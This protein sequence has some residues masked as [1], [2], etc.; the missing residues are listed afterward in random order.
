MKWDSIAD[1]AEMSEW[2]SFLVDIRLLEQVKIP[3]PFIPMTFTVVDLRMYRLS[4]ASELG[5]GAAVYVWVGGDDER[6]M[7]SILMGKSCV[8]PIKSVTL[9]IW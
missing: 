8:S 2:H 6:V 4:D 1:E 9:V 7:L 5:Y 3:R